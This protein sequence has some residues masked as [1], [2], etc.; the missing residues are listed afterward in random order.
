MEIETEKERAVGLLARLTQAHGAP[1]S[2]NEVRRI[3]RNELAKETRTDKTG[4][5]FCWSKGTAEAPLVMLASHMDEVGF[6]VQTVTK[7]GLIKFLP[8]GGWWAHIVLGQ[9]V[10]IL[11]Q[12]GAEIVGV[13]GAKPPHFLEGNER[14]KLMKIDD[15][16]IDVGAGSSAD[17]RGRFGIRPGDSIV[18]DSSFVRMHDPDLLLCK[19][20]DNRV[21]VA[22]TIHALQLLD[23]IH[24][25]NTV[26]GVGTVQ[27]ELGTRG[28]Q[29]A[30][31]SVNPDVAIVLEGPPADDLPDVPEDERQGALGRGVQVRLS[32]PSAIMNQY[33]A[34]FVVK[35][36]EECKIP[37]QIA[38]RK[39][40]GTD[41]RVIHL[42]R[43]GVPTI[44][45]GVPAR[46]IH[47][48][49]GI[50]NVQDYLSALDLVLRLMERL[51]AGV[52]RSF[53]EFGGEDLG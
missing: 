8:L 1:G 11:T 53:T 33:L 4:N 20:F 27:E 41:A 7:S 13:V 37:H 2:E 40:G 44:V 31:F 6:V 16:F 50:L 29:T 34:R 35:V 17:A 12:E 18:P 26:C 25:Q 43:A 3:F 39:S 45:L 51:D 5:V 22:L 38:V 24:R 9:R 46:Y 49:N 47:T 30:V 48:Q 21:G 14:E 36:A 52:V 28:A 23:G 15:M 32:D 42:H 19:A 10:R